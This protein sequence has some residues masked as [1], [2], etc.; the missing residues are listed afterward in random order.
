[1]IVFLK[2]MMVCNLLRELRMPQK[3]FFAMSLACLG[4]LFFPLSVLL[5]LTGTTQAAITV[6]P[7]SSTL[8]LNKTKSMLV[9]VFNNQTKS[10]AIKVN[11]LSWQLDENGQ[12]IRKPTQ[13]LL[14]FPEQFLL[15]PS[16]RRSIRIAYSETQAPSIEKSYRVIVQELPIDL[17]GSNQVQ[18]GVTVVTSYATAFY[19]QPSLPLSALAF[20]QASVDTKKLHFTLNNK[21]NAHTHL[22]KANIVM[23]QDDRRYIIDQPKDL[24]GIINENMLAGNKRNFSLTWP[25]SFSQDLDF[26]APMTLELSLTCESCDNNSAVLRV[27]V[28]E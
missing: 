7:L 14:I 10:V 20:E 21:G 25:E 1:M 18:S 13:D 2:N 11:M 17:A 23:I 15:A 19:V 9:T 28:S 8:D 27:P 26:T 6:A 24:N 12:D 3:R 4:K 22:R 5:S 16:S